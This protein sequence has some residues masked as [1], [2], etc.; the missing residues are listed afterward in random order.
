[1]FQEEKEKEFLKK[2]II[3]KKNSKVFVQFSELFNSLLTKFRYIFKLFIVMNVDKN[4]YHEQIFKLDHVLEGKYQ[5]FCKSKSNKLH[6]E[7]NSK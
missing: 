5:N 7:I 6:E 1:M 4:N 3:V 2:K